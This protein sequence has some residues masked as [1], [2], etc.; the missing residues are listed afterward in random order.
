MTMILVLVVLWVTAV[1]G[2]VLAIR[3]IFLATQPGEWS[4]IDERH[5]V[6]AAL[7]GDR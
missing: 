4:A 3:Y 5:R 6:D 1:A 2:A 7:R